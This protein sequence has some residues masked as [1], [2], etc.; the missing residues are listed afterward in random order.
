MNES[1]PKDWVE[2]SPAS[3]VPL[4]SAEQVCQFSY[5]KEA[6]RWYFARL[7]DVGGRIPRKN[8]LDLR[9]LENA[10]PF[11][12]LLAVTADGRCLFRLTGEQMLQRIGFNPAGMDYYDLVPEI[13]RPYARWAMTM[14]V[15]IPSS[16]HCLIE[17]RYSSGETVMIESIGFPL[18]SDDPAIEGFILF[19]EDAVSRWNRLEEPGARL[20]GANVTLRNLI[21][22]GFGVDE[23]YRDLVQV[24]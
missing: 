12:T 9:G 21:D 19:V 4:E 14:V 6:V 15:S 2:Q 11:C 24:R 16:F 20:L 7:R 3:I 23:T 13:R 18:A 5:G 1:D 8:G 17:Q 22:I 10:L